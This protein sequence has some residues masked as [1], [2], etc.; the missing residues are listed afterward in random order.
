MSTDF[1]QQQDSARRRT[2]RLLFLLALAV[3]ALVGLIYLLCVVIFDFGLGWEGTTHAFWH[4]WLL[5]G[6]MLAVLLVVGG[7]ALFQAAQLAAGGKAVALMLGGGEVSPNT[8]DFHERRLLNVV[9]EMALAS[10]VPVPAVFVLDG[11]EGINAFA[12]GH[13]PGDAV[14]AVSRGCLDYLTRDELQGVVAHEFSHILNGDMRLNVRMMALLHGLVVL[15]LAG[16]LIIEIA[17]ASGRSRRS[18]K[19][20]SSGA[21]LL[22]GFGVYFLG[23]L[24]VALSELIKAAVSRQREYLADASAVQFTRNPSGI[25]GALKK[26]GGLARHGAIKNA[27]AVEASHLFIANPFSHAS[28]SG[29]L[30]THPPLTDR[31]RRLEPQ[32]DGTFPAVRRL[33]DE[34]AAE[35]EAAAG[36]PSALPSLPGFPNPV[37]ATAVLAQ[38]E[39]TAPPELPAGVAVSVVT[40]PPLLRE[41]AREPFGARDL[42]YALLLSPEPRRRTAQLE[43]LRTGPQPR[44]YAETLRLTDTVLALPDAARLPLVD[45]ALPALRHLSLSQYLAFRE[46]LSQLIA[47]E[48]EPSLFEYALASLLRRHLDVAFRREKPPPVRYRNAA[49]LTPQL[50]ILLSRLAWEGQ[51]AE[52]TAARAFETGLRTYPAGSGSYRLLPRETCS[53]AAVD[54]AVRAF[55]EALPAIKRQALQACLACVM[56]DGKIV[57]REAELIRAIGSALNCPLPPLVRIA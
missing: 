57:P 23:L 25:A 44:D 54:G 15:S 18:S 5:L 42:V 24:G 37:L 17:S 34:P 46:Q 29:F 12:A 32:W 33:P 6:T 13:T 43:R 16:W 9:E 39:G 21:F 45:L 10:G 1:F 8:R 3:L 20:D 36:R 56:A 55:A 41:A 40:I 26:I 7:G 53:L 14:V 47:G 22:L 27:R 49:R 48:D 19:D 11:E 51:D 28:L 30:A 38:Q 31:I 50:T 52:R 35:T 2:G 4:P